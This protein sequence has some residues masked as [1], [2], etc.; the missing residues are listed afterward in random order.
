MSARKPLTRLP[1]V[2]IKAAEHVAKAEQWVASRDALILH[3][4]ESGATY[5]ELAVATGLTTWRVGQI[6]KRERLNRKTDA[7]W[8]EPDDADTTI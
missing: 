4:Q 5:A 8:A 1:G 7:A 6:L 3:A 2:T